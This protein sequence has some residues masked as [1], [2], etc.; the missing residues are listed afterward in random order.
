[1]EHSEPKILHTLR[2]DVRRG[3]F[4]RSVRREY[5]ELRESM[6]DEPRRQRLRTMGAWRRWLI[7]MFWLLKSMFFNLRP[8]RRIIL[9]VGILLSLF[10]RTFVFKGEN[11]TITNDFNGIGVLLILFVLALELKDKLV[12][13]KELEAGREIHK[14]LMPE[15]SPAIPGWSIWLFERPALD[16]GGDLVDFIRYHDGKYSVMLGDVS[17]KGLRAA[18]LAAKLQ[19]SIRALAPDGDSI[20]DLARRL[21]KIFYRDTPAGVFASLV[22]CEINLASGEL[23]VLNA[24]HL[25]P[26][27][28]RRGNVEPLPK[29]D[30]ALGLHEGATFSSRRIGLNDGDM[31]LA[32]S[33]GLNEA[34]N[35]LFE[36]FGEERLLALLQA[37]AMLSPRQLGEAIVRTVDEFA[38]EA[39][40]HDDLSIIILKREPPSQ[41]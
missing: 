40:Q 24:G 7:T 39:L 11:F 3:D 21:N 1:M 23:N 27:I 41:K 38:G 22:Y 15:R 25:P 8:A 9:V 13:R 26:Y 30:V 2:D 18:L 20:D 28:I 17:G 12:A 5:A 37:N 31:F 36:L 16:I 14:A 35:E 34:R 19:A 6:L 32:F 33:D 4:W 29:G 10:T